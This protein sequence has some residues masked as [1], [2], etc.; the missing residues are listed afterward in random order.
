MLYKV[1]FENYTYTNSLKCM[2]LNIYKYYKEIVHAWNMYI[3]KSQKPC[4]IHVFGISCPNLPSS[5]SY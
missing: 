2:K 3:I 4:T 1:P 5:F